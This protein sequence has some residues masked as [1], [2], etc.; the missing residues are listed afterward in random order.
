M[1]AANVA[2]TPAA[3]APFRMSRRDTLPASAS[4]STWSSISEF[5][6]DI[7]FPPYKQ[8]P[9]CDSAVDLGLPHLTLAP[10]RTQYTDDGLSRHRGSRQSGDLSG[11]ASPA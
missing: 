8:R 7:G 2:P 11:A 9:C 5:R 1:V 4:N 10:G 3:A 6:A